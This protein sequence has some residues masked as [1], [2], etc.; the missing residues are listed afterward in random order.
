M[1]YKTL[2]FVMSR[3][4]YLMNYSKTAA[5]KTPTTVRIVADASCNVIKRNK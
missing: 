4:L 3:Q 1:G 5:V 2:Y